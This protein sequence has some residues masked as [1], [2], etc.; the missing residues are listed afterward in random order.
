MIE[1]F[2]KRHAAAR[3]L[4]CLFLTLVLLVL[5]VPFCNFKTQL[6]T[7]IHNSAL[8]L[9][10]RLV[11]SAWLAFEAGKII[12]IGTGQPPTGTTII[13]AGGSY[14]APGFVDLHVHG[15]NGAD[16]LDATPEA[17][18]TISQFHA[19]GGTT[20]LAPTAATATYQKFDELLRVAA[21]VRTATRLLPAHLEGPHLSKNRAGAQD[22]SLFSNPTATEAI[23]IKERAS[24][25]GTITVAPELPGA[26]D[27]IR[28]CAQA[29]VLMSAGHSEAMDEDMQ[30]A[31]SFGLRK[32]THLYNAM[33]TAKKIGLFRQAGL[34]EFALGTPELYGELVADGFHVSP[35][36]MRLAYQAKGADRLILVTDAL[37]GAGLPEG[38]SFRLGNYRCKV[39][40]GYGVLG[41]ESALAGSLARMIDLVRN[42]TT[43]ADVPLHEAVWMASLN[44]AKSLGWADRIGSLEVGKY[45][46]LVLFDDQFRVTCTIASGEVV[47]R[48]R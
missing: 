1:G 6:S 21:K 22:H 48:N 15:G 23:W 28:G 5:L 45:A 32:A 17:F 37:A 16:F 36:L 25:I 35:T 8:V 24:E 12:T 20:A 42:M 26:L 27:F 43:L 4:H 41:D 30:A 47:Y 44:P 29:G 38:A 19:S 2:H 10:D 46:D 31:V 40:P 14:L 34:L 7:V 33:G 18:Q 11:P 39:G 3:T 9:P 13:D